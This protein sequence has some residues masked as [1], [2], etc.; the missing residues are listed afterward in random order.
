MGFVCLDIVFILF[1]L[2]L[3]I[4]QISHLTC[5]ICSNLF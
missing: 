5:D 3:L 1:R 4:E 2:V